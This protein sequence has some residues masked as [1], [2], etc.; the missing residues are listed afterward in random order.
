MGNYSIVIQ[1]SKLLDSLKGKKSTL[2]VGCAGCANVSTAYE[3]NLPVFKVEVEEKTGNRTMTPYAIRSEAE[4]LKRLLEDN[5]IKA[6]IVVNGEWC[7]VW[8]EDKELFKLMGLPPDF[9]DR[10]IDSVLVLTCVE[11]VKGVN[12]RIG[13]GVKVVPGMLT[14]GGHQ[15]VLAFDEKN[16][17]VLLDR[18]KS[19][20]IKDNKK[21]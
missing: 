4:R 5:K 8:T 15:S 9:K 18:D 3:K 2:I 7:G 19:T 14:V 11:G 13:D 1:D 16:E 12:R 21:S 10:S 17:F 20:F 6:E